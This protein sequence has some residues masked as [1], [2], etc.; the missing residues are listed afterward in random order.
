MDV[1]S[2]RVCLQSDKLT[3]LFNSAEDELIVDILQFCMNVPVSLLIND[4]SS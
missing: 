2:C 1:N 4:L 3:S